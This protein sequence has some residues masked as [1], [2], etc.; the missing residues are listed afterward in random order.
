[1]TRITA[2]LWRLPVPFGYANGGDRR[3]SMQCAHPG[4][5]YDGSTANAQLDE[6]TESP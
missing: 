5:R 1:M 6:E 3:S 2:S 4:R